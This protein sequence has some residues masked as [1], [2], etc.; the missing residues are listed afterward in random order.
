MIRP[1]LVDN[2]LDVEAVTLQ[3]AGGSGVEWGLRWE[4]AER[5]EE[6]LAQLLL[7]AANVVGRLERRDGLP[8]GV[9][10]LLTLG[11][12]VRMKHPRRRL[13]WRRVLVGGT[14]RS[15]DDEEDWPEPDEP[16]IRQIVDAHVYFFGGINS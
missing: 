15:A 16:A 14:S 6:V 5:F 13:G 8:P 1:A 10:V 7:P 4:A 12:Q 11:Q 9:E 3:R 2:A